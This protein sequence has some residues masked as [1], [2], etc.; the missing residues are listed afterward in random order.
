MFS[1]IAAVISPGLIIAGTIDCIA[2]PPIAKPSPTTTE[3]S[4]TGVRPDSPSTPPGQPEP[5]RQATRAD[6][7][8]QRTRHDLGGGLATVG[9][10]P[11]ERREEQLR[12]GVGHRHHAHGPGRTAQI[13][14][15]D[16][17]DHHEGPRAARREQFAP[18]ERPEDRIDG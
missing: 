5:Q 16:R 14:C 4:I 11:A 2:G 7:G 9:Q 12:G 3:D 15:Q 1:D 10:L 6:P 13:E 8:Q 17:G 18:E